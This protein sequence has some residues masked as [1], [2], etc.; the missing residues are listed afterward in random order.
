MQDKNNLIIVFVSSEAQEQDVLMTQSAR[1]RMET[2]EISDLSDDE[3]WKYL[4]FM[5]GPKLTEEKRKELIPVIDSVTGGR[6]FN[7]KQIVAA[8]N[9]EK[10]LQ[11]ACDMILNGA[12]MDFK[13]AG[14]QNP[15][16]PRYAKF[17]NV[18]NQIF[19]ENSI[20]DTQACLLLPGRL[21]DDM[22]KSKVFA[23]HKSSKTIKFQS[24]AHETVAKR[25]SST[26][27]KYIIF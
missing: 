19:T 23:Y 8:I 4:E 12:E 26:K 15:T 7:L 2:L 27:K 20:S 17:W 25:L 13:K 9:K 10:P 22:R 11:R 16:D 1:S 21:Y 14:M 3:V 6:L 18:A 24:K 5:L